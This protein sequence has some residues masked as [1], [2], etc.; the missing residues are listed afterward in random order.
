MLFRWWNRIRKTFVTCDTAFSNVHTTATA[1]AAATKTRERLRTS[2]DLFLLLFALIVVAR[3]LRFVHTIFRRH[4]YGAVDSMELTA[5]LGLCG[6]GTS[7]IFAYGSN[8]MKRNEKSKKCSI[9][10]VAARTTTTTTV[11]ATRWA[12]TK[13]HSHS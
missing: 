4:Y 5:C 11:I 9:V 10:V 2:S 3:V 1:A 7:P 6:L 12:H 8:K 13:W